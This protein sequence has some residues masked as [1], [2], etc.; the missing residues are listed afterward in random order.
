MVRVKRGVNSHFRHKKIL[1]KSKGYYGARSRSFKVAKQSV[2]KSGQYSYID[3]KKKKRYFRKLW[4]IRINAAVKK[5]GLSYSN[6]ICLLKK[7]SVVINRKI[8]SEIALN[9][10]NTFLNIINFLKNDKI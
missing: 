10:K 3:R 1:K 8:L 2:I 9:D 7:K 6:F 5:Y 4:N